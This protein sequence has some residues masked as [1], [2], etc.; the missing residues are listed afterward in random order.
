MPADTRRR[1]APWIIAAIALVLVVVGALGWVQSQ[2]PADPAQTATRFWQLLADGKAQDAL[3]LSS[4]PADSVPNG[5]LLSDDVYGKADR[6]IAHVKAGHFARRGD[7]ASGIVSYSQHGA[8]HTADVKL[9]LVRA[10]FP[11][12]PAWQITNAPLARVSVTVASGSHADAL[13]V[14]GTSLPLP[15]GDGTV[16]VPALPGSYDFALGDSSGLFSPVPQKVAVDGATAS[17]TLGMSPSKKLGDQAVAQATSMLNGCFSQL[18]LAD[19]CPLADGIR[20]IFNLTAEPSVTYALT[21]VPQ[22]AFDGKSMQVTSSAD[23][24]ITTTQTDARNGTFHT[25]AGFSLALDVTVSGGK[26]ALAPHDGGVS[27]TDLVCVPGA[28]SAGC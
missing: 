21:R 14:D 5:L 27:N 16:T 18:T 22:L 10:G 23:G 11:S 28:I 12:R 13:S 6:G 19:G 2:R 17:V 3:A 9:A 25:T 7:E 20:N 1:R 4:T 15:G 8:R 26:I 24:E